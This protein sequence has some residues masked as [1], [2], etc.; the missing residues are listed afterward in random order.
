MKYKRFLIGKRRVVGMT[1]GYAPESYFY[2]GYDV[3]SG[4]GGFHRF[5]AV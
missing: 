4:V 1:A 5:R 3:L 2:I